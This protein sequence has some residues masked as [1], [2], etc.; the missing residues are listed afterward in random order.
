[1]S[2]A[3]HGDENASRRITHTG[4]SSVHLGYPLSLS[5]A[6]AAFSVF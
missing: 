6:L 4:L 3:I 5:M 1:M 2:Y